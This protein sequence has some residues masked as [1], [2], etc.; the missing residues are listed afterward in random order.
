MKEFRVMF[1]MKEVY[2]Y[3]NPVP[4]EH[5]LGNFKFEVDNVDRRGF[6]VS[7]DELVVRAR[8]AAVKIAKQEKTIRDRMILESPKWTEVKAARVPLSL[9]QAVPIELF[10]E[11]DQEELYSVF[12]TSRIYKHDVFHTGK[13]PFIHV[14]W[15]ITN[16]DIRELEGDDFTFAW[17]R[18]VVHPKIIESHKREVQL[19]AE[20]LEQNAE[21]T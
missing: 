14:V 18:F 4:R 6:E 10:K 12:Y 13:V 7:S 16:A 21:S 11:P 3:I 8:R 17:Q 9:L 15:D 1:G 5:Q 2:S 19:F 20:K